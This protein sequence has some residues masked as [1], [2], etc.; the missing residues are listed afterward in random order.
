NLLF[1]DQ[2]EVEAAPPLSEQMMARLEA[3]GVNLGQPWQ[4][5]LP[6]L[7]TRLRNVLSERFISLREV[8]TAATDGI[9]ELRRVRNLGRNSLNE[10]TESLEMLARKGS[11]YMRYGELGAPTAGIDDLIAQALQYLPDNE[12]RLLVRRFLDGATLEQLGRE[13][14]L[15]RERIRQKLIQILIKL[16]RRLGADARELVKPLVEVT[17]SS[18]GLLHCDTA[19]TLAGV[20][21]IQHA[22]LVLAIAGE[23]SFRIWREEFLTTLEWKELERRLSA[24]R[25]S[26]RDN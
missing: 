26:F 10:L 7:S 18:G 12:G 5:E 20:K 22:W 4:N 3:S 2:P 6:M 9:D 21:D 11:G 15:T 19:V 23:N 17:E 25:N 14:D 24:I 8:V 1:D 13:Y 16:H